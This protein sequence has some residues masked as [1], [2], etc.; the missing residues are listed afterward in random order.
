MAGS[1]WGNDPDGGL[2][3]WAEGTGGAR[4]FARPSRDAA[5]APAVR[6]RSDTFATRTPHRR[7][8]IRASGAAVGTRRTGT[9]PRDA[10]GGPV[11]RGRTRGANLR[12]AP[13]RPPRRRADGA[14]PAGL[15][16]P[17]L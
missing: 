1:V 6:D 10:G 17:V 3:A 5:E 4:R 14:D 7:A 15:E 11:P 16:R 9:P 8:R 13:T 12:G 2:P